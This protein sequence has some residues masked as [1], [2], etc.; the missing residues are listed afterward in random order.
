M[1]ADLIY[2]IYFNDTRKHS[3]WCLF[4]PIQQT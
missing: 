4:D 3:C 1:L 2:D